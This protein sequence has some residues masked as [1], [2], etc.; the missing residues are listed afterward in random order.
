MS[1]DK[2][3]VVSI[4]T[5]KQFKLNGLWFGPENAKIGFIFI[6]GLSGDMFGRQKILMPL[7]NSSTMALYFNNRGHDNVTSI[8]R[9]NK[10]SKGG[11]EYIPAG[12]AHEVFTD[13]VDDI[14]GAVN[15]LKDKGIKDIYLV[16]HSTGC[17]KS[18]YYLSR[19]GKKQQIKGAILLCPMS[20]YSYAV[21][22]EE[23]AK[24][25]QAVSYSA[26]LVKQGKPHELLPL[27]L[28]SDLLD[29]Q[30][31][32]SLYTPDSEEEVFTYSQP[33]KIPAT[34]QK[35]KTPL[36]VILAENDEYGDRPAGDIKEW[37]K[38]SVKTNVSEINIVKN[39][40]HDLYEHEIEI[41]N[42]ISKWIKAF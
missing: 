14:Q 42:L 34:L 6:H 2:C 36:N 8:K 33:G 4:I 7:V 9:I 3:S 28:S 13:C 40:N 22:S 11:Y 19:Q 24:L 26:K 32:L 20:D 41:T 21:I 27:N 1:I 10:N 17:Q 37:F 18:I 15:L 23:P 30:R 39:A 35:V 29:A 16:G 38:K 25:K 31:F 12:D 5:P